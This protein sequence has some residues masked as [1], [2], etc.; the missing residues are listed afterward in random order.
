V[1]EFISKKSKLFSKDDSFAK[2]LAA[3]KIKDNQKIK[4]KMILIT[5]IKFIMAG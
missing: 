3:C 4:E 2:V 5:K 1:I